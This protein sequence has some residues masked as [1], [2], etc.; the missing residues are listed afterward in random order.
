[1]T[2]E[3]IF[4][5]L[6]ILIFRRRNILHRFF[7]ISI[8]KISWNF[9]NGNRVVTV[10]K[11]W[12]RLHVEINN[13][14]EKNLNFFSH[15]TRVSCFY[16]KLHMSMF[17]RWPIWR[18]ITQVAIAESFSRNKENWPEIMFINKCYLLRNTK[19]RGFVSFLRCFSNF[20]TLHF[21]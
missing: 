21:L 11:K 9:E 12:F 2:L 8:L 13:S 10:L 14:R 6:K 7:V 19:C 16:A 3:I 15:K 5:V 18:R 4:G 1:M 20:T 17:Q